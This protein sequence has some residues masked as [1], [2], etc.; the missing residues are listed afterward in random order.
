[1]GDYNLRVEETKRVSTSSFE[2]VGSVIRFIAPFL[3]FGFAQTFQDGKIR[4]LYFIIF[5]ITFKRMVWRFGPKLVCLATRILT[6]PLAIHLTL[7]WLP[8]K[9]H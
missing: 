6:I 8:N 4:W 3:H 5:I 1:M 9:Q 2:K 7:R